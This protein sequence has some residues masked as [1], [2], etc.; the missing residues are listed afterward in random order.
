MENKSHALAAGSFVLLLSAILISLASWLT[1]DT[2]AL[3]IY[4]L[5]GMVNVSGLQPQANVRYWGV[6]VGKVSAISLDPQVRG[7]VLVRIAVEATTP[8][9]SSTYATLANQGVT[10]L[11]FIQLDDA[12][13]A[14]EVSAERLPPNSRILLKPSLINRLTDRAEDL[15]GQL[16]QS[17]QRVNLWLSSTNQQTTM[18]TVKQIGEAASEFKQL[19]TQARHTLPQLAQ[20]SRDTLLVLQAASKRVG[21]SADAAG[22]AAR[23]LGRISERVLAPGGPLEQFGIG[24]DV[25]IA[26]GQTLH[27]VTLPSVNRGVQEATRTT[28][29]IS[30]LTQTL[31][32]HPQALLLGAPS[33]LPG[34]GEPGF[35]QPTAA[36]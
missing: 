4:E 12:P 20:S 25:L 7:Q 13:S 15:L 36:Q 6:S 18:D 29:Q 32:R 23:T 5:A 14:S 8:I 30:E 3:Q 2:R 28:R 19:A 34:P 21:D 17:S 10:G 11:A 24:A 9:S 27:R 35:V 31:T 26:T 22:N 1:R 33:P 16:E